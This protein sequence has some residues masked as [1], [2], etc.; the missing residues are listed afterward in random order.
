[1][2]VIPAIDLRNGQV[3][4]LNQGDYAKQTTFSNDP[5]RVARQFVEAGAPRIHLVDLDGAFDG[6]PAQKGLCIAIAKA[7]PVP[8]EL[9][10][11]F[12]NEEDVA[13]AIDAGMDRVVLG[14]VAVEDPDLV[15]RLVARLGADR[16]IVGLDARDG[17]VAVSGWKQATNVEATTLMTQMH[18]RGVRRYV[19]TDISRDGTLSSPNF[20]AVAAMAYHAISLSDDTNV[21]ASG[22][23][24]SIAHLH[25]LATLGVEGAIVGSAIYRGALDLQQAVAELSVPS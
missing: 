2:E 8:I 22:G 13:M 25:R 17:Y 7:V 3:V 16:I 18:E 20:G 1:V 19:Y 15:A 9:G 14:T 23:I 11:G 5:L 12:R 21:I 10:G 24:G 4:R 6:S